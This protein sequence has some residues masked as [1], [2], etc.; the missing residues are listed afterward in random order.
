MGEEGEGGRR[1]GKVSE[2]GLCGHFPPFSG[3]MI[4]PELLALSSI[5]LS[6]NAHAADMQHHKSRQHTE[7]Q[8]FM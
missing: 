2:K 7:E 8:I 3:G 4:W 6:A 5:R 1:E